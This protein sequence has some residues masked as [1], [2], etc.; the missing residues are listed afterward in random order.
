MQEHPRGCISLPEDNTVEEMADFIVC[1]ETLIVP[2][3]ENQIGGVEYAN[4]D[5]D[6]PLCL[7]SD[8]CDHKFQAV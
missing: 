3:P 1:Y 6:E 2:F 8:E 7:Y 5:K 4:E